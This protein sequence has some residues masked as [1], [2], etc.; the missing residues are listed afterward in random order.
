MTTFTVLAR[1]DKIKDNGQ[2]ICTHG[3]AECRDAM[4]R[5]MKQITPDYRI[6]Y[7]WKTFVVHTD[8]AFALP[9]EYVERYCGLTLHIKKYNS[10]IGS[11]CTLH[12]V[13]IEL[14]HLAE[15]TDKVKSQPIM[16]I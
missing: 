13:K 15:I 16:L 5:L 10:A 8:K 11:G 9:H 3:N 2:L 7:N 4:R 6:P 12:L 1:L 14:E